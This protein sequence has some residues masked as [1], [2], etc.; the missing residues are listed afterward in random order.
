MK[1]RIGIVLA[2][3]MLFSTLT[4]GANTNT[5]Q[6]VS[7]NENISE[8][9]YS[10]F[11]V[12]VD[13]IIGKDMAM[14]ISFSYAKEL[15]ENDTANITVTDLTEN[16]IVFDGTFSSSVYMNVWEN[17]D[18]NKAFDVEI[19]ET[20]NGNTAVYDATLT[21][22][23]VAAD[24]PV[25]IKLNNKEFN[26]N[27][28]ETYTDVMIKKVGNNP[29]CNHSED[30]ECTFSCTSSS[31]VDVIAS[32]ELDSFYNT[33]DANSFYELQADISCDGY[34]KRHKG[35]IS[36]YPDGE[37][38][39]IFTRGFSL[40]T[41]DG[42]LTASTFVSPLNNNE[43]QLMSVTSADFDFSNPYDYVYYQ[44]EFVGN[45]T[46]ED[47]FIIRWT[48]PDLGTYV[49]ETIGNVDTMIYS[50]NVYNGVINQTPSIKRSGGTGGN[51][52]F[53]LEAN[54]GVQ[55]YFVL[56]LESGSNGPS[57][58]RIKRTD[59][60]AEDPDGIS[61]YRDEVQASYADGTF[62]NDNY[63]DCYVNYDGDVN[64][65]V[66]DVNAGKGEIR[67]T[68]AKT[69]MKAVVYAK[70]STMNGPFDRVWEE[71]TLL[72]T[73]G[74]YNTASETKS[75]TFSN[76]IHYIDVM[77]QETPP[78]GS[79]D[80]YAYNVYHYGFEFADPLKK[81]HLDLV[82]LN[83]NPN[84]A[85]N[86][87][88]LNFEDENLTLHYGDSDWFKFTTD[89]NGGKVNV[90]MYQH[91]LA[92]QHTICMYDNVTFNADGSWSVSDYVAWGR[93]DYD[94][95]FDNEGNVIDEINYRKFSYD[96]E[97]NH[98]Y[99]LLVE[100]INTNN[101]SPM[102]K[103]KLCINVENKSA[104]LSNNVS[105]SHTVGNDITDIATLKNTVME[106][107]T[108][109]NSGEAVVDATAL[110]NVKLYSGETELTAEVVNGLASGEYPI[111][112]KYYD[113]VATG[114]TVTLS[115]SNAVTGTLVEL[116]NVSVENVTN[117]AWDWVSC[118]K[119]IANK[120]LYE[121]SLIDSTKP[122]ATIKTIAQALLAIKAT[123]ANFSVRGSLEE[124]ASAADYF[125]TNGTIGTYNFYG[126]TITI[127]SGLENALLSYLQNEQPVALMLTS[128]TTP[129]DVSL[130]RYVVLVGINTGTHQLKIL[131]PMESG[132]QWVSLDTLINGGYNNNSDLS[133]TGTVVQFI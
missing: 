61:G 2:I 41:N 14:T 66:Y 114:A 110:A 122:S 109:Y 91:E 18:N 62:S 123:P 29:I 127:S 115:V 6:T 79:N 126:S 104:V 70:Q 102:R 22:K 46:D 97:P 69:P 73:G 3:V 119:A 81:D 83:N 132:E 16:E 60:I 47:E 26:Y 43:I 111:T 53:T 25:N 21:T 68:A 11:P 4:A 23:L 105:L 32:E 57:A 129:T 75:Y 103:Y 98:T 121:E 55:R 10:D 52:C 17:V 56:K 45:F 101:Y 74:E 30:E 108:C 24:F 48:A 31:V 36:T 20:I 37:N 94:E 89:A 58:F 54:A 99:Y 12:M 19:A 39:G 71:T 100:P 82:Q 78:V 85:Y 9:L 93:I 67:F 34:T 92:N 65:F 64:I 72:F 50:F 90:K 112:V 130:A 28:G 27:N 125:Y 51:V 124:T 88:T 113:S 1:K 107:L 131:D 128:K 8:L 33:L 42:T 63:P 133:F 84:N 7:G 76:G 5:I 118:A 87:T 35:F 59:M 117:I 106:S 77:Q 38:L 120:R 13:K 95:V 44:N 40:D 15:A 49:F 96:L 116:E 86:I 80:Y